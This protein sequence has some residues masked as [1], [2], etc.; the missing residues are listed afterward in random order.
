MRYTTPNQN[1]ISAALELLSA[2]AMLSALDMLQIHNLDQKTWND[3]KYARL[4]ESQGYE[5]VIR[6]NRPYQSNHTEFRL[7]VDGQL[8]LSWVKLVHYGSQQ[9]NVTFEPH[10]KATYRTILSGIKLKMTIPEIV[11]PQGGYKARVKQSLQKSNQG[12]WFN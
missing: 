11:T 9:L 8:N 4:P 3:L 1:T 7:R 5:I 10:R 12:P 6:Y 2:N